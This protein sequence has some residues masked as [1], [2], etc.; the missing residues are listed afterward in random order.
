M[1][2]SIVLATAVAAVL[3]SG[4]AIAELSGN[5]AVASNYIWRGVTQTTDQAAGQGGIDWSNDS[6]LYV[7]TWVSNVDFSGLGDGYEMD[8][9]AGFS[10]EAGD[11]GYDIG[12]ISYQYPVTPNFNF[13]EVYVS[14]SVSMV[15]VGLAYTVDAASGNDGGVFDSGDMYIN[16][17]VDY[18][19]GKSDV[20]LYAGSYLFDND[21]GTAGDVDYSHVGASIGKD[22]FTFAVDKN[23]IDGGSAD[24]VR[25]TVSYAMDF[26]L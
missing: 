4:V 12:V 5:A 9:Y 1:K 16:G 22:G 15:T 25:F 19:L 20:S 7:G 2:K 6:G 13:T 11:I 18:T 3:T 8:V 10:G 14:G 21:G 24:N 17:S 23:D 26:E